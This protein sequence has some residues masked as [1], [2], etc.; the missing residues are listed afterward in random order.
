MRIWPHARDVHYGARLVAEVMDLPSQV[1]QH[2]ATIDLS[3]D[4]STITWKGRPYS[5]PRLGRPILSVARADKLADGFGPGVSLFGVRD[6]SITRFIR[7]TN[8]G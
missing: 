4:S 1:F 7:A 5:V 8:R 6:T 3:T 2:A